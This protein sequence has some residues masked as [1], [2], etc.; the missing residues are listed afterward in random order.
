[1]NQNL[2][3]FIKYPSSSTRA[4]EVSNFCLIGSFIPSFIRIPSSFFFF[5]TFSLFT[6]VYPYFY[7]AFFARS[8]NCTRVSVFV[9]SKRNLYLAKDQ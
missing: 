4:R 8:D 5:A 3:V 7:Y 9:R 6:D 2:R 1:M